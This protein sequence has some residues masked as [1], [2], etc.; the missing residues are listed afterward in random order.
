MTFICKSFLGRTARR[1]S[2]L[3][4]V[5]LLSLPAPGLGQEQASPSA[6]PAVEPPRLLG[7]GGSEERAELAAETSVELKLSIDASG[8]VS[9]A[10][11]LD[12]TN[13]ELAELARQGAHRLEFEPARRGG[14]PVPA[15]VLFR[16]VFKPRPAAARV[17][18]VPQ[19]PPAAQ[20]S[21]APSGPSAKTEGAVAISVLGE[22]SAAE[23]LQRSA[24]AVTVVNLQRAQRRSA[25]MGEVMART[26]GVSVRRS[27]GL[28]SDVRFSLNGLQKDQ[29]R[30][31]V[32]GVPLELRFPF[33]NDVSAV[34]VNL[35]E[36]VEIYRGVVPVRLG[37]DALGG[38]LNLV[39]DP[40]YRTRASVSYQLGS[41]GTQRA[42][43]VARFRNPDTGFVVGTELFGDYA[44]NNYPVDVTVPDDSGRPQPARVRRFHDRY[45]AYGAA[46]EAGFV[47]TAWT[48]RL[49][50]RASTT[51]YDKE[52]QH[53][54]VMSVPYGEV[55]Y[56]ERL[57][58]VELRFLQP[59]ARLFEFEL[60]ASYSHRSAYFTDK[61]RWV[62][63]WYGERV[64][65][66]AIS[67]EIEGKPTDQEHWQK[68]VFARAGLLF[69]PA[70]GH[71]LR[72][73]V[74]PQAPW[75]TGVEHLRSNASV[76]D[77]L[78]AK[79]DMFKVVLGAEYQFN[80]F[81][82]PS[83]AREAETAAGPLEGRLQ[84]VVF[85]KDYYYQV[86]SEEVLPGNIWRARETTRHRQGL[87]AGLRWIF[88]DWLYAKASYEYATRLP[89][90]Y[91]VFGD[92]TLIVANLKLSPEISH[93]GNAGLRLDLRSQR[94]GDLNVDLNAF[95]RD[96]KEQIVLLGNDRK[97]SYQNLYSAFS[98]GLEGALEWR[99]P[100][101]LA[102]EGSFTWQEQRNTSSIGSFLPYRGDRIPYR[103]WLQSSWGARFR[104]TQLLDPSDELEP[105]YVGRFVHK[106][107]RSWESIGTGKQEVDTQVIHGLGVTYG[108]QRNFGKVYSTIEAQNFTDAKAYD[109]V[110]VQ[111][112]GRSFW[113]KVL[114]EL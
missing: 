42:A 9:D 84:G 24:D 10:L 94:F 12:A 104:F 6:A 3:A 103:P 58:A 35:V 76:R 95:V 49:L 40:T 44:L 61:S 18:E 72:A 86:N 87:G 32:D 82:A 53:N 4:C 31:Y 73:T 16:Y 97:W 67:G 55:R 15:R 60:L 22:R 75:R 68:T 7:E 23:Q 106:F 19:A 26:F 51:A 45:R 47:N 99:A 50:L 101:Y 37:G 41:F 30:F 28:G 70:P 20:P 2:C 17:P 113:F 1:L 102:L 34:P 91:E 107:F 81:K 27:G 92:G 13:P 56:G 79:H 88:T 57:N 14:R 112:P 80:L 46:I 48:G 100:R 43:A 11:V 54:L 5:G 71:S 105:F 108:V 29:L 96:T 77:P 65:D 25:D 38:A 98:T 114:V 74:T 64:N 21:P 83:G 36:R 63:N 85:A 110:G 109:F 93:N 62:Y 39:G 33:N 52:H 8:R 59:F 111:K 69:R 90:P 89:N 78:S 66:R